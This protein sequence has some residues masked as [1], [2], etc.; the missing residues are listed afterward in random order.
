M[1]RK[2]KSEILYY[3]DLER[4]IYLDVDSSYEFGIGAIAYIVIGNLEPII[5]STKAKLFPKEK[6]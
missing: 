5:D 4:R 6:I 2:S 3:Y 1:F